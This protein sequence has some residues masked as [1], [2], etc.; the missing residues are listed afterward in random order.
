MKDNRQRTIL[1][2]AFILFYIFFYSVLILNIEPFYSISDTVGLF[3]NILTIPLYLLG[4]REIP[5][6]QRKP[7]LWFTV[8]AVLYFIGEVIWSYNSDYLGVDPEVPHFADVFYVANALTFL[9]GL[10]HY[11]KRNSNIQVMTI[12]LDM[13]ISICAVGGI[14]YNFMILPII[15]DHS[16]ELLPMLLLLFYPVVDF[17]LFVG[18]LLLVFGT[19]NSRWVN[20]TNLFLG[21]SLFVMCAADHC[22]LI[23]SLYDVD[24]Y[25]LYDPLWALSCWLVAVAS[26]YYVEQPEEDNDKLSRSYL[27][28]DYFRMTIPYFFNFLILFLIGWEYDLL[29]PLF[30]WAV[31]LMLLL[32]VRQLFVLTYNKR[33]LQRI[34]ENEAELNEQNQELQ[35]LNQRILHD[36]E[37]DFLT[38]LFNRRYIDKVFDQIVP[39][40]D[41]EHA[42]GLML[43]DVDYFKHVNDTYGHQTGDKVLQKVAELIRLS[44]GEK[45]IAGR[46]GGD[47]FIVLLPGAD[48]IAAFF[49]AEKL[50][51]QTRGD[52]T[53]KQYGVT[54]SIGCT[55]Q[56][57]TK[58]DYNSNIL[59]KQADEALYIA[60][61]NGRNQYIVY[62]E[63]EEDSQAQDLEPIYETDD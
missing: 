49:V 46:F 33:L 38:Q 14:L 48:R 15:T 4:L 31:F 40:D 63:D 9:I 26:L 36:A 55:A 28:L 20:R 59:L 22:S 58:K 34:R 13:V 11:L 52:E 25:G 41:G 3:A 19:N 21:L 27:I 18:W 8:S 42:L 16:E 61:E 29:R 10:I 12:S 56:E 53:L 23:E 7:W 44:V 50:T 62:Y 39:N 60:K 54:L 32:A 6:A 2:G 35:K 57:V 43:I 5:A 1:I 17:A 45:D 30:L 37:V 24:F 51:Q 47:E